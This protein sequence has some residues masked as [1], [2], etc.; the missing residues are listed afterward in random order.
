MANNLSSKVA[1]NAA[2]QFLGKAGGTLIGLVAL[3]LMTRYLGSDQFGQYTIINTFVTFFAVLADLGLISVASQLLNH[4]EFDRQTV[5]ANLFGFR[6]VTAAVL[7]G[8]APLAIWLFPY[9]PEI[10][11]GALIIVWSFFFVALSQIWV[12]LLQSVLRSNR[13]AIAEVLGRAI[14]LA[15][16]VLTVRF[17]WGIPGVLWSFVAY[18]ATAWLLQVIL[19]WRWG[20]PKIAFDPALWQHIWQLAWPFLAIISLNLVY[21]K[22]DTLI[23]SLH[24]SAAEVGYYGAAYK[25]L[26]VLVTIPFILAGIILPIL[27]AAWSAGKKE[28]FWQMAQKWLDGLWLI[29]WPMVIFGSLFARPIMMMVAGRDFAPAGSALAILIWAAMAVFLS[30]Y[31]TNILIA[32]RQQKKLIP[33]YLISAVIG[34]GAYFLWIPGYGMIGAAWGTVLSEGLMMLSSA[35]LAHRAGWK[36][37]TRSTG[38][39]RVG[40]FWRIGAA[41]LISLILSGAV[42]SLW[43]EARWLMLLALALLSVVYGGLLLWFKAVRLK[44]YL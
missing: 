24:R 17:N 4:D 44:D 31:F 19:A 27:V 37:Q 21:M 39:G 35:W 18:S 20:K 33:A 13:L 34:L 10:K 26:D 32:Q 36:I 25:V 28:K 6:V 16:V 41:A 7:I 11:Q 8:L 1:G 2:W 38:S 22:T 30:A 5:M 14:L 15:V 12:G 42:I 40:K 3:G 29:I 23:L 43:P 9:S